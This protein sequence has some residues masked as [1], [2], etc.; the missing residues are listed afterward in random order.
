MRDTSISESR[1]REEMSPVRSWSSTNPRAG[2]PL[3]AL[4]A[5]GSTVRP[6]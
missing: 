1:D 5:A 3:R 2:D 4:R 6:T